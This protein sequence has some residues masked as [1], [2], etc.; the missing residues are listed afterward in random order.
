MIHEDRDAA[1]HGRHL[2]HHMHGARGLRRV[3]RGVRDAVG[4][5]VVARLRGV[6]LAARLD[7]VVQDAVG[8]L[9]GVSAG[10]EVV[11]ADEDVGVLVPVHPDHDLTGAGGRGVADDGTPV[12]RRPG[13]ASGQGADERGDA[14]CDRADDACC[15]HPCHD[16]RGDGAPAAT[17]G[18]SRRPRRAGGGAC[19]G[20]R[21]P[22]RV[23]GPR[24]RVGSSL[25]PHV[26][27]PSLTLPA[28]ARP[29][30]GDR[31]ACYDY[32]PRRL[33]AGARRKK[34]RDRARSPRG[35][36]G[37]PS[38]PRSFCGDVPRRAAAS[39]Q[40]LPC[41]DQ[42]TKGGGSWARKTRGGATR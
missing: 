33:P 34:A 37:A 2:V 26:S 14:P 28:R 11:L 42:A 12:R 22:R 23:R 20:G 18:P 3:A 5:L 27:L 4:D 9:G 19:A 24:P 31:S 17:G 36:V 7:L 21:R 8:G 13:T 6:H 10:L 30:W 29:S 32:P 35:G 41:S 38:G 1:V 16:Q 40:G 25:V 15:D 39:P